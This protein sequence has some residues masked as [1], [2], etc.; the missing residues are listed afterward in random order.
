MAA[1]ATMAQAKMRFWL[2]DY[3]YF[4]YIFVC[5]WGEATMLQW[6]DAESSGLQCLRFTDHRFLHQIIDLSMPRFEIRCRL[7]F[8]I[9]INLVMSVKLNTPMPQMRDHEY[10][11]LW[12][13]MSS[14]WII[15]M[16]V[17]RA[18]RVLCASNVPE[19]HDSTSRCQL[20][21]ANVMMTSLKL[22]VFNSKEI[23][24]W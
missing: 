17:D 1:T 21:T 23:L 12:L 3:L 8:Y 22:E 14:T 13:Y 7:S 20:L 5:K 19:A 15:M 4:I 9:L 2:F 24:L 6:F 18:I 10:K 11:W 16:F